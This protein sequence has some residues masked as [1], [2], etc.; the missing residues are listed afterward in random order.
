MFVL[1]IKFD[2]RRGNGSEMTVER[3]RE[4]I[5]HTHFVCVY[6]WTVTLTY[7]ISIRYLLP[8]FLPACGASSGHRPLLINVSKQPKP[9]IAN[10]NGSVINI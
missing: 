9:H 10:V 2:V 3:K 7:A 5:R 4:K 8:R 1:C 6:I